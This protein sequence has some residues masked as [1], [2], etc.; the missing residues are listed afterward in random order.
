MK[1]DRDANYQAQ[2]AE[3]VTDNRR[4]TTGMLRASTSSNETGYL[5]HIFSHALGM[6]AADNKARV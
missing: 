6:L 4:L 2:N 3:G 5:T 1:E